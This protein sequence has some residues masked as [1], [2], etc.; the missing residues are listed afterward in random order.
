MEKKEQDDLLKNKK[1]QEAL[2]KID[3][4]FQKEL[5][6]YCR[7]YRKKVANIFTGQD[8]LNFAELCSLIHY[9]K[10]KKK[11]TIIKDSDTALKFVTTWLEED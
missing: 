11:V 1:V 9:D 8:M 6:T 3:N 10:Q 7:K 5:D 4:A 2:W